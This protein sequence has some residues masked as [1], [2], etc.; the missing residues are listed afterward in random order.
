[1]PYLPDFWLPE[2]KMWL[3][4]K[5]DEILPEERKLCE[6]LARETGFACALAKGSPRRD[7]GLYLCYA[8]DRPGLP[9]ADEAEY[10]FCDDRR[11]EG[12]Y[13]LSSAVGHAFIVIQRGKVTDHDRYPLIH[14]ATSAGYEAAASARFEHGES[15]YR[16]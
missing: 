16:G 2:A 15:G 13:W 3:E 12:V 8:E 10:F 11:D 1:V 7:G 6:A 5:G 4:V 14:S 9:S